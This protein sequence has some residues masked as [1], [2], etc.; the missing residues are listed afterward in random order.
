MNKNTFIIVSLI[1]QT[2]HFY[3]YFLTMI[4]YDD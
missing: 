1:Q 2:T 3:R 4:K